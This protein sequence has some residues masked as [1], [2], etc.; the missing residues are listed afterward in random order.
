MKDFIITINHDWIKRLRYKFEE[1]R[2]ELKEIYANNFKIIFTSLD[3]TRCLIYS[4]RIIQCINSTRVGYNENTDLH[5]E[6][7]NKMIQIFESRFPRERM[8]IINIKDHYNKKIQ[9][10]NFFD[11][12][13]LIKSEPRKINYKII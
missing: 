4:N 3:E 12:D 10:I 2:R 5:L 9:S 11:S 6:S 8:M 7:I 1:R 13:S